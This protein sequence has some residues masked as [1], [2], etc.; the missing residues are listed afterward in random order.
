MT[1]ET[2]YDLRN[3][4]EGRKFF[5]YGENVMANLALLDSTGEI[6]VPTRIVQIAF[7]EYKRQRPGYWAQTL[8]DHQDSTGF[9]LAELICLLADAAERGRRAEAQ[10]DLI[11]R[12]L[13]ALDLE[14]EFRA[15]K[16]P[17]A[18]LD[19]DGQAVVRRPDE[20]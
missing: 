7:D 2:N 18:E 11:A 9:S 14:K 1:L 13:T 12:R 8:K 17:Y 5:S 4:P 20:A 19:D 15:S 10:D 3:S 16:T 6:Q